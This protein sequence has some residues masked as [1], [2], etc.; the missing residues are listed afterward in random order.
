MRTNNLK[1]KKMKN[2]LIAS[3]LLISFSFSAQVEKNPKKE[4]G[5]STQIT[6][7]NPKSSS[8]AASSSVK[9]SNFNTDNKPVDLNS[10]K[11][12]T[13]KK[14]LKGDVNRPAKPSKMTPANSTG[15]EKP[16]VKGSASSPSKSVSN[17]RAATSSSAKPSVTSE[18]STKSK[19][20]AKGNLNN[21]VSSAKPSGN[22]SEF[23]K[24]WE[25]GY[26][27]GWN[28][29]KKTPEKPNVPPCAITKTCDDYK[30]GYKMGM[31]KAESSKR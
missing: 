30:C 8:K 23:C 18:K 15:N 14:P 22:S 28:L 9:P 24:G 3:L 29:N 25:D 2:L 17:S 1:L 27:K 31:K 6:T 10:G 11:K 26:I 4:K 16:E 21:Q 5:T 7:K 12:P 19:T 13:S 20:P